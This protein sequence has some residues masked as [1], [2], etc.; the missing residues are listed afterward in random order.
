M[1]G[2]KSAGH[3]QRF[4]APF[5]VIASLFRPGRH[6]LAARNYREI[7][8]RRFTEWKQSDRFKFRNSINSSRWQREVSAKIHQLV[9]CRNL[10]F[11]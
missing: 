8:R 9:I 7:M 6:L 5:G 3:A 11:G 10:T 2:F 4:L 1:R